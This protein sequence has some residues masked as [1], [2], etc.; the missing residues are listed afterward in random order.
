[1][2]RGFGDETLQRVQVGTYETPACPFK[3]LNMFIQLR[4]TMFSGFLR[5]SWVTVLADNLRLKL[6]YVELAG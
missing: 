6:S 4:H 2:R 3:P 5:V 1:M